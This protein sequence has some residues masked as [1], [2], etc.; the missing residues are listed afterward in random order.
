MVKIITTVGV[1]SLKEIVL[2][3]LKSHFVD[4]VRINLSHTPKDEI[5]SIIMQLKKIN[6]PIIID[7]EGSMIRTG[8]FK[9]QV[10]F[11]EGKF[12]KIFNDINDKEDN[13]N[14]NNISIRP[15]EVLN[16][17]KPGHL[18]SVDFD[19]VLV[20]VTDVS[21]L[22]ENNFITCQ[23]IIGGVVGSN[24]SV[25]IDDLNIKLPP[26]SKKDLFAIELAKKYGI[27]R[28]TLSFIDHG[29]E[30]KFFKKIYPKSFVYAEIETKEGITN[31]DNFIIE[32]DGIVID[33][34]DLGKE[35]SL[36]KIP[37]VQKIIINRC[38]KENKEV[39]VGTHILESM[40]NSLKPT[41][42]EV[43]DIVNTILDGAT[44]LIL[45][46]ETAIGKYPLEAVNM[47]YSLIEHTKLALGS[48]STTNIL[49]NT[50][51][52]TLENL[53]YLTNTYITHS[54]NPPHGG[55]LINRLLDKDKINR[56]N[57]ST[58]K[59]LEVDLSVI[60]DAEQ[61]AIG[62][63]SPLQGF[64]GKGDFISILN[65]MKLKDGTIWPVPIYLQITGEIAQQFSNCKGNDILLLSKEDK[66]PYV[67]LHLEEIFNLD[68]SEVSLKLFGTNDTKHPGVKNLKG[69]G[70][71]FMGGKISLINRLPSELKHYELT[72]K[73]TR[74]IF[75]EKGW[76]RIVGFI[77]HNAIHRSHEIIQLEGVNEGKC[78]GLFVHP[79]AGSR[80]KGD[81]TTEIIIKSYEL[82]V[83]KFYPK[84]VIFSTFL[85]FTRWCGPREALFSALCK[86][87]FG[88]SHF[89]VGRNHAGIKGFYGPKD[90]H[91]IFNKFPDLGI[92]PICFN[93]VFYSKKEGKH[94]EDKMINYQEED[95]SLISGTVI[96]EMLRAGE[97]PSAWLMRPEISEMIIKQIKEG[98]K[99]F[100][101]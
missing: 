58:M 98:K 25:N 26:F 39:L 70:L 72:P 45:T 18:I 79:T 28:F 46:K 15:K 60:M 80:K 54:L 5:E 93:N 23:V 27:N 78:D 69:S 49:R 81:F 61:I 10:V 17:L 4:F 40:C 71:Y 29:D 2:N 59:K 19:S 38:K 96:R 56:Y 50:S 85:I 74:K 99:V 30:I 55:K 37:L 43:N 16:N 75:K 47:L 84:N 97:Q 87:N 3:K 32:A 13:N 31:F 51:E 24:K 91:N 94:I 21:T 76:R 14:N 36:E 52:N 48:E 6:I 7:T 67:I 77:S 42:S 66:K 63:Y 65:E 57:F 62:T 41:R 53:D 92:E 1:S 89:I 101:E 22:E 100:F 11:N 82:M 64:V 68:L 90:A 12:I 33:R 83:E 88:C 35:I 9:R 44:G 73:Q 34:G 20:K 95:K 8:H 86:K